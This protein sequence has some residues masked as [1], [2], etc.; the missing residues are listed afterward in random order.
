MP[1]S[2]T[3]DVITAT[4]NLHDTAF[5][6]AYKEVELLARE[7]LRQPGKAKS[8]CMAMGSWSFYDAD[9]EPLDENAPRYE[10][11]SR[12]IDHCSWLKL[13]GA[14]MKIESSDGPLITN[15]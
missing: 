7:V 3:A 11:L 15:W 13:T 2:R 1:R 12:F 8:F 6:L 9:G 14:P 10:K 5:R 4:D